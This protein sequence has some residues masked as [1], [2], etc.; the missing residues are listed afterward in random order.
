MADGGGKP[1]LDSVWLSGDDETRPRIGRNAGLTR[2]QLVTAAIR[3]LDTDGLSALSMRRLAVE[4]GAAPMSLYWYVPTKS[5]L[6]EYALDEALGGLQVE[7]AQDGDWGRCCEKFAHD[8]RRVLRSRPWMTQLIGTYALIG[9]NA[10]RLSEALLTTVEAGGFRP[11]H[12]YRALSTLLNYVVGFAADEVKWLE[13]LRNAGLDEEALYAQ[14]VPPFLDVI[15]DRYP[16]LRANL[17]ASRSADWDDQFSFGL[18][19]MVDGLRASAA[20][21]GK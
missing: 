4:L 10:R 17:V 3:M 9:P 1:R 7:R 15:G 12:A 19:C 6:L 20:H 18:G 13:K 16:K 2:A 8:L 14:W 5:A 21:N 11:P